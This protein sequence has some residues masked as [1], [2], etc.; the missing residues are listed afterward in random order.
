MRIGRVVDLSVPV[1]EYTQ[2]YPGDPHVSLEP[3]ATLESDGV[4][5]TRLHLGSH[6]GTHVDAPYHFVADGPRIDRVDLRLFVGPA[7]ILDVRGKKPRER[8]TVED[9]RPYEARLSEGVIAVVRTGWEEHYGTDRYYE[10]PFLDRR[11]AQL[12]LD[13]GVM[14]V[15]VDALNVDET[16]VDGP[17]PEGYPVHRLVLGAG[18]IIAENLTNLGAIDFPDPLMS[19]LPIKLAGSDGA[20]ARA[21]AI[22]GLP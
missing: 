1:D 10:H 9:L 16:V 5:V 18:G 6:S 4:N 11:A 14:T 3:A 15:A 7:V 2:V 13:S 21:V 17:H 20:P 12:L 19:L 22:E 8:I